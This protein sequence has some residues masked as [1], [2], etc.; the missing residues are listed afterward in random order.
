MEGRRT[1]DR[2]CPGEWINSIVPAGAIV[3]RDACLI[4]C[5]HGGNRIPAPFRSWFRDWQSVLATHR[6]YDL[7][8]LPMARALATALGAN[9][10]ISTVSRLL[11]DLNRS[12][13]HPSLF[14]SA[15]RAAPAAVRRDILAGYYQPYRERVGQV[16]DGLAGCG[17]RVVHISSHSFT[18][19]LDGRM[20][21]ADIGLLYDPA[22]PGEVQLAARWKAALAALAPDYLVRRNYPS[23]IATRFDVAADE[24][25][26]IVGCLCTPLDILANKAGFPRADVG[27]IAA[28]FCAGA[29]GASASP[30]AFLGQGPAREMLV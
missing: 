16:V 20:R 21:N 7:G 28:I 27:D 10:E 18:P 30:S 11:V 23:A 26:S 9:I 8:A 12:P 3:R 17:R 2:D 29:Y 6:G 13:G 4:T 5:E 1:R 19:E 25:A 22:R 24:E 15:I 14:S